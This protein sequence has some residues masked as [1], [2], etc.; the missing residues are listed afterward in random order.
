MEVGVTLAPNSEIDWI[1]DH[2]LD[3]FRGTSSGRL[4]GRSGGGR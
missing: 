1:E 4:D 2:T 3:I